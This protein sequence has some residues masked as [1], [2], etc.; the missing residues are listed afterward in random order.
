[1]EDAQHLID[2]WFHSVDCKAALMGHVRKAQ[3]FFASQNYAE[4]IEEFQISF[5]MSADPKEKVH[6]PSNPG[7]SF[8]RFADLVRFPKNPVF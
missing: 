1:M 3:I 7:F 6:N 2:M 5:R 4:A 8:H